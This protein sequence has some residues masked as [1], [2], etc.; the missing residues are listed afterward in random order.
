MVSIKFKI[1]I[2]L[3]LMLNLN[4]KAQTIVDTNKFAI[5]K[6]KFDSIVNSGNNIMKN[7][8]DIDVDEALV[9]VKVTNTIIINQMDTLSNKYLLYL[10]SFRKGYNSKCVEILDASPTKGMGYYSK[11]YDVYFPP[12]VIDQEKNVFFI[13]K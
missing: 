7:N 8:Y 11:K 13:E 4:V 12:R 1:C 10:K 3:L 9:F 6:L 2:L 5:T